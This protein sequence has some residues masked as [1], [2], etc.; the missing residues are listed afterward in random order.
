M[1]YLQSRYY[2]PNLGRFL[3]HDVV[4]DYDA[5]LQGYDLF[6]YCGNN[7]VNRI[8]VSGADSLQIDDA[9]EELD[10]TATT[11]CTP[12]GGLRDLISSITEQ[13]KGCADRANSSVSGKGPVAGTHKHT[14]FGNEVRQLNISN[15]RVEESYMNH[16]SAKYGASGSIRFD[17]VLVD[18]GGNPIVA[19]DFKT[20]SATLSASRIDQ[21]QTQSG[22]YIPIHVVR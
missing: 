13:L 1:Y 16:K 4:F 21:M 7:R 22:F 2:D 10:D 8:D 19:W 9:E 15:V 12:S 14:A 11:G 17:V 18:A 3:N 6:V 5:G 20:G